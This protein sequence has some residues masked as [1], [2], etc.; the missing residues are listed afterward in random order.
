MNRLP[1]LARLLD[2]MDLCRTPQHPD[3]P[4]IDKALLF[5][6]RELQ[7]AEH[8]HAV[9][10]GIVVVPLV[11]LRVQE[12][13]VGGEGG[14]VVDYVAVRKDAKSQYQ[15][16]V[17]EGGGDLGLGVGLGKRDV[18]QIHHTLPPLIQRRP[19]LRIRIIHSVYILLP[20]WEVFVE[21]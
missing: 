15:A 14:V 6:V 21:P 16:W 3:T 8:G 1:M 11:A 10:I 2:R 9:E 18:R 17:F 19:Q 7:M 20:R 5:E 13:D 12:E 4:N